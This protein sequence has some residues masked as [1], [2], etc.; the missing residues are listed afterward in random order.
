[1]TALRTRE[2]IELSLLSA[3]YR[4]YLMH[5]AVPFLRQGLLMEDGGRLHLTRK[6]IYVSDSIMSELMK[7]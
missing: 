3:E 1:M 4:S 7:V 2:G 6:G 5:L